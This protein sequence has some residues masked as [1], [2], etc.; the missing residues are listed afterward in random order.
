ME[1][2]NSAANY[3]IVDTGLLTA[4]ISSFPCSECF[5][6]KLKVSVIYLKGYASISKLDVWNE[7]ETNFGTSRWPG[8]S[9]CNSFRP[10][11]GR[12][13]IT[14]LQAFSSMGKGYRELETFSK[15]LNVKPIQL[16]A[17]KK[18]MDRMNTVYDKSA[19][20]NITALSPKT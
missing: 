13:R 17:Y 10:V 19:K 4:F 8:L 7:Y 1:I 18:H 11:Y 20:D 9:Q 5:K 16:K 12:C 6:G 14:R 2:D 15:H 3:L